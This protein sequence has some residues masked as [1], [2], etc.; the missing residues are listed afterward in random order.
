MFVIN[1]KLINKGERTN[2]NLCILFVVCVAKYCLLKEFCCVF[3][4]NKNAVFPD[5]IINFVSKKE[6]D[7]LSFDYKRT[8]KGGIGAV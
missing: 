3:Y 8:R 7:G 2:V 4:F 5:K 6:K 1:A